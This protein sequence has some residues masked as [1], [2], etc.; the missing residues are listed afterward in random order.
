[1]KTFRWILHSS[2][3]GGGGGRV[4]SFDLLINIEAAELKNKQLKKWRTKYI[5]LN[6]DS[7]L[8]YLTWKK[9]DFLTKIICIELSSCHKFLNLYIFATWRNKILIF[10]TEAIWSNSFYNLKYQMSM[11]SS[12]KDIGIINST[13][14]TRS[15]FLSS[16]KHW[17]WVLLLIHL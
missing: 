7:F 5:C 10:H 12:C 9:K 11:T 6:D 16:V 14:V 17:I 13:F 1:M 15:K 4:N 3:R 8:N 2:L